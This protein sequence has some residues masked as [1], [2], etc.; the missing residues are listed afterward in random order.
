M[1]ELPLLVNIAVALAYALAGGL[2]ARRLGLPAIVGYLAAGAARWP[3]RW[4]ARS[5]SCAA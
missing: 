5:C 1:S 4:R 2:V 3:S